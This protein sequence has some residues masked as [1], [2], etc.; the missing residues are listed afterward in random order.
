MKNKTEWPSHLFWGV[1]YSPLSVRYFVLLSTAD[2]DLVFGQFPSP[3]LPL[4]RSPWLSCY[5]NVDEVFFFLLSASVDF[6]VREFTIFVCCWGYCCGQH[7]CWCHHQR[8]R[9]GQILMFLL[10]GHGPVIICSAGATQ[11]RRALTRANLY[12]TQCVLW[13]L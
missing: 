1:T 13:L 9:V 5:A 10:K 6:S 12:L 4:P 7:K 11:G 2:I 3:S 8:G